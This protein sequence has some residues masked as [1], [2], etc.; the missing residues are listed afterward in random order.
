MMDADSSFQE[1][2][3]IL[4]LCESFVQGDPSRR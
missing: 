4:D 1:W 3:D 2:Q